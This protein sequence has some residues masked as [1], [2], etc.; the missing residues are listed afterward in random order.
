MGLVRSDVVLL[1]APRL[2]V[3]EVGRIAAAYSQSVIATTDS[4]PSPLVPPAEHAFFMPVASIS[5]SM[6]AYVVFC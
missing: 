2:S 5:N 4:R 3:A 6:G 1:D